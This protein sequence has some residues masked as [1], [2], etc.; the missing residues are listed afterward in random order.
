[1]ERFKVVERETKTK[2]YSKEGKIISVNLLFR[3]LETS[4]IWPAL[5]YLWD[6]T[7]SILWDT[8]HL[9]CYLL[10]GYLLWNSWKGILTTIS[11]DV[12]HA[13]INVITNYLMAWFPRSRLATGS[14]VI[15]FDVFIWEGVLARTRDLVFQPGWKILRYE[16]FSLVTAMKAGW[17]LHNSTF[18]DGI[19]FVFFTL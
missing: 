4:F 17:I 13:A 11:K 1:M 3:V 19:V 16:H 14:F 10:V 15:F 18:L 12:N 2:A 9:F 7:L 5:I 6:S 8:G